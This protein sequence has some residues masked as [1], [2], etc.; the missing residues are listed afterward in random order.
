[1]ICSNCESESCQNETLHC[2]SSSVSQALKG[3][4][5]ILR[6][7]GRGAQA[8]CHE[9]AVQALLETRSVFMRVYL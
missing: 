5:Q 2:L 9:I 6:T 1:M 7:K 4:L 3:S 8:V